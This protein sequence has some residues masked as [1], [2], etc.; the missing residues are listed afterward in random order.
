MYKIITNTFVR[1]KPR[2]ITSKIKRTMGYM[3]WGTVRTMIYMKW[4]TVKTPKSHFA[5]QVKLVSW[6]AEVPLLPDFSEITPIRDGL[7]TGA[8]QQREN[9]FRPNYSV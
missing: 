7:M 4:G 6:L 1:Y 8:Y 2:V 5:D 9:G 3:N